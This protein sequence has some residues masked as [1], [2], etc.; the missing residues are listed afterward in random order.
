M[1][2]IGLIIALLLVGVGLYLLNLIP[3]DGTIKTI[4]RI[5]VI[6]VV[7]LW[8]ISGLGLFDAGPM[9]PRFHR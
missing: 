1:T 9:I 3:M 2:L 4:I 7:V 5:V 6:L 8:V